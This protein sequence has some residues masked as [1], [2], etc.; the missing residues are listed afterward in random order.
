MVSIS[1]T[2]INFYPSS[3]ES[4]RWSPKRRLFLDN[5]PP[6]PLRFVFQFKC[7]SRFQ[8]LRFSDSYLHRSYFKFSSSFPHGW[9]CKSLIG[10]E[11][12]D[13]NNP[14][15]AY[16]QIYANMH[17]SVKTDEN[18]CT[19]IDHQEIPSTR[20]RDFRNMPLRL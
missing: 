7:W 17:K 4:W 19:D 3:I 16:K 11:E 5:S 8:I 15:S 1:S 14:C 18:G 20:Y 2:I 6:Y 9:F 10:Q 12:V 13:L